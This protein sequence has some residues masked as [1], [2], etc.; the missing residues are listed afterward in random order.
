MFIPFPL[1]IVG[2]LVQVAGPKDLRMFGFIFQ[3]LVILAVFAVRF[4]LVSA[5]Q[6]VDEKI[7]EACSNFASKANCFL[8]YRTEYT[9]HCK[10]KGAQTLRAIAV[11]PR[12]VAIGSNP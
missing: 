11:A 10:P 12:A 1:L 2:V 7:H 5:N 6:K 4:W 3:F 8:E 9:G